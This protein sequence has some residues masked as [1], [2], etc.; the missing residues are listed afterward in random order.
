MALHE[1]NIALGPEA[2]INML[3]EKYPERH[4]LKYKSLDDHRKFMLLDVSGEKTVFQSGLNY[5]FIQTLGEVELSENAILELRYMT[6]DSWDDEKKRPLGLKS[7]VELR[8]I[9]QDYEYLLINSWEDEHDFLQWN[10]SSDNQLTQ[11]GH[12]GNKSAVVNQYQ[13]VRY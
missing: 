6:L 7:Y 12:A 2:T 5:R 10:S 13:S 9:K 11:F 1:I 8:S 3:L 4:F